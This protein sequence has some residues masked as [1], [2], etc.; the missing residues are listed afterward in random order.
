MIAGAG[1]SKLESVIWS[2]RVV[3]KNKNAPQPGAFQGNATLLFDF[4]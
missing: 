4:E 1:L 2:V 3:G